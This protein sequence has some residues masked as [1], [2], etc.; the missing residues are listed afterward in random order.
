MEPTL[1]LLQ[2]LH[3]T[4]FVCFG[5]LTGNSNLILFQV[6]KNLRSPTP[7][8][9]RSLRQQSEGRQQSESQ[10]PA[11]TEARYKQPA[12][13]SAPPASEIMGWKSDYLLGAVAYWI[14]Q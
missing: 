8:S 12:L 6:A 5:L 10:L 3:A 1:F 14:L 11:E 9:L 7:F 13:A 4:P 2:E